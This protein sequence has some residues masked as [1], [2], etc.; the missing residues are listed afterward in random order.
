LLGGGTR[1]REPLAV[2]V[3]CRWARALTHDLTV[4]EQGSQMSIDRRSR[5]LNL[6]R[7]LRG[8]RGPQGLACTMREK[9]EDSAGELSVSH[10]IHHLIDKIA[11]SYHY[12]IVY[13][14]LND[15]IVIG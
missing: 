15:K 5:K 12:I 14:N 11:L 9:L 6:G 4:G 10:G 8:A 1:Y 13:F 3:G 2:T 7:D